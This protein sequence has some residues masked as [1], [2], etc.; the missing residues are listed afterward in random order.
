M[1]DHRK[2]RGPHPEDRKLFAGENVTSLSTATSDFSWLLSRGYASNSSLKLVGDRYQLDA[3]QR[4][5][6][7]RCGCPDN[8]AARR[9]RHEVGAG[10]LTDQ[11]L[12]IDG[13]NL[14]T[15]VEAALAGGVVLLGKDHCYRDMASMHGSSHGVA[16]SS[17]HAA[18]ADWGSQKKRRAEVVTP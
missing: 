10:R 5:A 2:H 18:A 7:A 8:S 12:W 13:F 17:L 14:I 11:E 3:R 9:R 15:T 6:V 4:I 16:T 1:P